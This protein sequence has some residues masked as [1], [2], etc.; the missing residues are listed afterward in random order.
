VT[1]FGTPDIGKELGREDIGKYIST[2]DTEKELGTHDIRKDI[3]VQS[4]NYKI[5]T[6][7]QQKTNS[8]KEETLSI[9]EKSL[10]S[11]L[12]LLV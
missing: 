9:D 1:N 4:S 12:S 6:Y 8:V 7:L 5:S 2:P 10:N 11:S 3:G